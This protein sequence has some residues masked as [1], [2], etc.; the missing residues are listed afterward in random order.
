MVQFSNVWFVPLGH[1]GNLQV[2]DAAHRELI[3]WLA[4]NRKQVWVTTLQ[5]ALDWA[6]SHP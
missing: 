6:K 2:S 5:G 4:A 1:A 3:A